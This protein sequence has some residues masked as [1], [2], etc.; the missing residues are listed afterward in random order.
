MYLTDLVQA[1]PFKETKGTDNYKSILN[2]QFTIDLISNENSLFKNS[3]YINNQLIVNNIAINI[4][5]DKFQFP[6]GYIVPFPKTIG[7][8]VDIMYMLNIE[9][10]WSDN[11]I[12]QLE[13]I[14]YLKPS[15]LPDYFKE[16][17]TILEKEEEIT[18]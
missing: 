3:T 8:Y 4:N 6:Q 1:L 11:V 16:L 9:L 2:Q 13:P 5:N 10:F 14:D 7:D 18:F 15:K 17:L 12:D